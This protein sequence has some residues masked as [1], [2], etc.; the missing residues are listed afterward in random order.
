MTIFAAFVS[1]MLLPTQLVAVQDQSAPRPTSATSAPPDVASAERNADA[2]AIGEQVD[3]FIKAYNAKDAKGLGTLFTLNA[4]IEDG[5]G[6]I[7]RGRDAIVARFAN[8][9]NRN[10]SGTLSVTSESLRFL[11]SGLAIEDG[12]AWLST[13]SDRPSRSNRYSVIYARE[14]GRWLHARIRDEPSEEF[15]AHERLREL[16]W[17]LGE[18]VN[19]SDD[20]TVFTS[21]AFSKDGNF[22]LRE[23]EVKVEGRI[24]LSGT[25][26]IAWDEQ[27]KQFRMWVFDTKG[28]FADGLVFRDS[29]RWVIK[30]KGVRSDGVTVSTTNAITVL[31]KDRLRWESTDRTVGDSLVAG[32][33]S[34]YLVRRP[35]IPGAGK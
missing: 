24:D 14:G 3:A 22:L 8:A 13:Q 9:F 31:G 4:E 34:F 2:Q 16:S 15:D 6:E 10:E 12:I 26:R 5:D 18:W 25:Q 35:P 1:V 11:G 29:D 27:K 30:A 17:M 32:T 28:G 23:F 21:C 20:A 19:E 33:D 7:T